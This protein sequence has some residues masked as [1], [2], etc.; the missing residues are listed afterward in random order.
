MK[1]VTA[2]GGVRKEH[3][4]IMEAIEWL[5]SDKIVGHGYKVM[6][7]VGRARFN[8]R[9]TA[10]A[11]NR[12]AYLVNEYAKEVETF[13]RY[14]ETFVEGDNIV[15]VH[16]PLDLSDGD[17]DDLAAFLKTCTEGEDFEENPVAGNMARIGLLLRG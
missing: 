3:A 4:T 16:E 13:G 10:R 1:V 11:I 15:E 6:V 5:T 7:Q 12:L 8:E 14:V 17:R 9:S 2:T